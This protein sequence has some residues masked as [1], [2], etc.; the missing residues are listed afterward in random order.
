MKTAEYRSKTI[1]GVVHLTLPDNLESP[2]RITLRDHDND[3]EEHDFWY[4]TTLSHI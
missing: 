4:R 1:G 2:A 3:F